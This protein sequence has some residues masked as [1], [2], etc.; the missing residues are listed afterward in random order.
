MSDEYLW[1]KT[2]VPD[3][4]VA[5][6]ERWAGEFGYLAPVDAPLEPVEIPS[7][8]GAVLESRP[9]S[10]FVLGALLGAAAALLLTWGFARG[11][12]SPHPFVSGISVPTAPSIERPSPQIADELPMARPAPSPSPRSRASRRAAK[13]APQKAQPAVSKP[14]DLN[15][16]VRVYARQVDRCFG[17]GAGWLAP[18]AM[19][20]MKFTVQ[21]DGSVRDPRVVRHSITDPA[22]ATRIA[23][24]IRKAVL[25]W[26]MP[27]SSA[28]VEIQ[29]PFVNPQSE[30]SP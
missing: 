8:G 18:H 29:Y 5:H 26:R 19:I 3:P 4:V 16:R 15:D 21:T 27:P 23:G 9:R 11:K 14:G 10:G 7:S 13:P 17:A 2:G 1:D 25:Q 6:F 24:C 12:P 30:R 20:V 28:P 22:R